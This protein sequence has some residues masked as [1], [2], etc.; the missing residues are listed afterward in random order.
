MLKDKWLRF[1]MIEGCGGGVDVGFVMI[2]MFD[3]VLF[4]VFDVWWW[5]HFSGFFQ[6][7]RQVEDD[8]ASTDV[9]STVIATLSSCQQWAQALLLSS[10]LSRSPFRHI[11]SR[12]GT[13]V[14]CHV[15]MFVWQFLLFQYT[16]KKTSILIPMLNYIWIHINI[17]IVITSIDLPIRIPLLQKA[18]ELFQRQRQKGRQLDVTTLRHWDSGAQVPLYGCFRK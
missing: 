16:N 15:F 6:H 13:S 12:P 14:I 1:R 2:M 18:M 8:A 5:R 9:S 4:L 7:H 17:S 3:D 11:K 10:H